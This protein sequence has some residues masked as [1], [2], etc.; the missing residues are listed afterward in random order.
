MRWTNLSSYLSVS[1]CAT[2]S[3]LLA[4]FN[5]SALVKLLD[6]SSDFAFSILTVPL[7]SS[8]F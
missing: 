8:G 5:F 3:I 4:I 1:K 7:F 2:G 6:R